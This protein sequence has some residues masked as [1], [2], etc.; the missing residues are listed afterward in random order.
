MF[1]CGNKAEA[2]Q[3]A[4]VQNIDIVKL[5]NVCQAGPH[6]GGAF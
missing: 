4:M 2:M 5:K 3:S 1:F 6:V